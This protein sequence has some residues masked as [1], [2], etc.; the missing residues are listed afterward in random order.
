VCSSNAL[1]QGPYSSSTGYVC[2]PAK[3]NQMKKSQNMPVWLDKMVLA[4]HFFAG[5]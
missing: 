1:G 3:E 2:G 4:Q 5:S